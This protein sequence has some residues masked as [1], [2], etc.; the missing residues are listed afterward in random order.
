MAS[1]EMCFDC[2]SFDVY[3]NRSSPESVRAHS[4]F[5]RPG[6]DK[7][8]AEHVAEE[9][10]PCYACHTTHGSTVQKRLIVT[11]R[12]PGIRNYTET[13]SGGT[14]APTCHGSESYTVNYAR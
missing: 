9:N 1:N 7:G 14:C 13:A 4:R 2:H 11:G 6:A 8:H 3:A 12:T 5:N 10:V